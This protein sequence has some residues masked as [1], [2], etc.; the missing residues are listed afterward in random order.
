RIYLRLLPKRLINH[1]KKNKM[2]LREY[3]CTKIPSVKTLKA[4]ESE[5]INFEGLISMIAEGNTAVDKA[6]ECLINGD[7]DGYKGYK[8]TLPVFLPYRLSDRSEGGAFTN[9]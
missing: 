4:S 6:R 5:E 7:S 3:K 8:S 1:N 2:N 9:H